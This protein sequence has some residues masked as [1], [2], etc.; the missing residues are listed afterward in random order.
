MAQGPETAALINAWEQTWWMD[1]QTKYENASPDMLREYHRTWLAALEPKDRRL[2]WPELSMFLVV[3]AEVLARVSG[4]DVVNQP[5]PLEQHPFVKVFDANGS[6]DS[7]SGNYPGWM[8][9]SLTGIYHLYV[10]ALG[11]RGMREL[12]VKYTEWSIRDA[13]PEETY[14]IESDDSETLDSD[15]VPSDYEMGPGDPDDMAI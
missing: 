1:D 6:S 7:D 15:D 2:D 9:L 12:C 11:C 5:L 13:L 3:D 14:L 4:M 8:K 10:K